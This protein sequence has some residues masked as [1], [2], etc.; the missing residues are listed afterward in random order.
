M[1]YV[2]VNIFRGSNLEKSCSR[3]GESNIFA[4]S[5]FAD[6]QPKVHKQVSKIDGFW[7][8]ISIKIAPKTI[9]FFDIV[10][11]SILEALGGVFG[12]VLEGLGRFWAIF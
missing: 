7:M 11:A 2:F 9:H 3:V 8:Q 1:F 5:R 6:S 4:K 10:F 12:M